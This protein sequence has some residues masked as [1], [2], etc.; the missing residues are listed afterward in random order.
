L[1]LVPVRSSN[2]QA[3]GYDPASRVMHVQFKGGG[4]YAHRGVTPAEHAA[5]MAAPSLGS[6]YSAKFKGRHAAKVGL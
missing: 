3:V 4:T 5:F 2:V 6:H 1:K